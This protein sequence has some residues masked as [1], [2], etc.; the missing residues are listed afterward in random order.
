MNEE[1]L[2]RLVVALEG[3]EDASMD[4][5]EA[6]VDMSTTL[7]ALYA[8]L[9]GCVLDVTKTESCLRITGD[10]AVHHMN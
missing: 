9:S 2:A 7:D 3:I 4:I 10:I 1:M 6:L 5:R 8:R